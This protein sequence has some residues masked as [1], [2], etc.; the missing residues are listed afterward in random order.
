MIL[1]ADQWSA[2][3][4]RNETDYDEAGWLAAYATVL[5]AMS[6]RLDRR[7]GHASGMRCI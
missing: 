7:R 4:L 6:S 1:N 2:E 5:V 3:F